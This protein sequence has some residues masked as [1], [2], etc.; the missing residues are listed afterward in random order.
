MISPWTR[1]GVHHRLA[2]TTDVIATMAEILGLGSL[3]QFDFY[4]E[5]LRDIWRGAP[6]TARYTALRPTV[7]LDERTMAGAPGSA[8]SADLDLAFEDRIPDDRFNRILW[9]AIKGEAVAY[10][11][12]ERLSVPEWARVGA[13]GGSAGPMRGA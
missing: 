5:P 6:D 1:A 3:S 9:R 11:E 10:P 4:G 8:E 13:G 7:P 2:N 12:P